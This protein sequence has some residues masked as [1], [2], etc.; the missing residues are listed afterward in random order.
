MPNRASWNLKFPPRS[1]SCEVY[2][3]RY[4]ASK[5]SSHQVLSGLDV[6]VEDNFSPLKGAKLAVLAHQASVTK[7][8]APIVDIFAQAENVELTKIFAPEHGF[9]GTKQDMER[10]GEMVHQ[11]TG[12]PILSLYDGG[13]SSLSPSK[14]AL[15][16]IDG[17][18]IDLQDVGTRYYTYAQSMA[19]TMKAAGEAG[20]FVVVLDR[21][22]PIG[23]RASEG[24]ILLK[25]FRSFCG[26]AAT[27]VRHGLTMGELAKLFQAGFG[28]GSC[29][30]PPIHCDL[31]VIEMQN[32][33]RNM[34]FDETGLPWVFPS[35]NMPTLQTA[36]VYPGMCLFEATNVSEGRGTTMPFELIGAPYVKDPQKLIDTIYKQGFDL[37]GCKLLPAYFKPGFQKWAGKNCAGVQ[38]HV[39][40]RES[41]EPFRLGL[42][43]LASFSELYPRNFSWRLDAY[44]FVQNIPA[45]DLL[46]GSVHLRMCLGKS[47]KVSSLTEDMEV[48][49]TWYQASRQSFYLY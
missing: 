11:P 24:P 35:P 30:T 29:A 40:D 38:I 47:R 2:S 19:Y 41:F 39:T 14:K 48:F 21:P 15:E 36:I 42:A 18:V 5:N 27:G 4:M 20:V 46:Y 25:K 45:I 23:G 22:N 26:Y 7:D 3:G 10:V 32:W 8:L 33:K 43:M 17:I 49:E 1:N 13:E 34:Y 9:Y 28:E 37:P 31:R 6:L 16:D 12:L 44:E